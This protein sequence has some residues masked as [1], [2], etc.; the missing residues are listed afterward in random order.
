MHDIKK[1][2]FF[3]NAEMSIGVIRMAAGVDNTV[4]I[5]IKIVKF[6]NLNNIIIH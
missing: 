4:H 3:S 5:E 2:L 6:W 1:Y